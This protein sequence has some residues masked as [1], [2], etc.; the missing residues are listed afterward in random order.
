MANTESEGAGSVAAARRSVVIER[1]LP[2]RS[3]GAGGGWHPH[4]RHLDVAGGTK[5]RLEQSR[6]RPADA[7]SFLDATYGWRGF[8]AGLDRV[9]DGC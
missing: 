1:V 2:Y 9:T 8:T 6:F 7:Q 5:V 3:A 4:P